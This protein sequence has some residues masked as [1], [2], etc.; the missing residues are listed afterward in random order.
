MNCGSCDKCSALV[1]TYFAQLQPVGISKSVMLDLYINC[2]SFKIISVNKQ[3]V[4]VTFFVI[5]LKFK[6]GGVG[7]KLMKNTCDSR[8][9]FTSP[10]MQAENY[11][12]NSKVHIH[13]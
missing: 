1:N 6:V 7:E 10:Q 11:K 8:L 12:I 13:Y 2:L 3:Q 9:I 4:V 5:M